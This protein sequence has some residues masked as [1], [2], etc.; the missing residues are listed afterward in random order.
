MLVTP[1][2]ENPSYRFAWLSYI[3]RKVDSSL[4]LFAVYREAGRV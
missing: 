4:I 2:E 3:L 1:T